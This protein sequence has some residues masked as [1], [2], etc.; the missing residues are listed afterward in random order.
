M[1]LEIASKGRV[2]WDATRYK[3]N[4]AQLNSLPASFLH[5]SSDT[6]SHR[7]AQLTGPAPQLPLPRH[8]PASPSFLCPFSGSS[9]PP[10]SFYSAKSYLSVVRQ[11][12]SYLSPEPH[13]HKSINY[14]TSSTR[15]EVWWGCLLFR[16]Q[17]ECFLFIWFCSYEVPCYK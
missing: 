11:S 17:R 3:A 5:R 7:H 6:R 2:F 1:F 16:W 8:P 10:S 13:N 4:D 15:I 14:K 12:G 9:I